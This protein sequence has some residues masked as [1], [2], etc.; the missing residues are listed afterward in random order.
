M[1][2]LIGLEMQ[3]RML[4]DLRQRLLGL[5]GLQVGLTI[6]LLAVAGADRRPALEPG[7]R[8]RDHPVAVVDGDRDADAGR[9]EA[10]ADRGRAGGL[11]GAALPGR[12]GASA[13][14]G[15]AA[16]GARRARRRSR[17][18]ARR[19]GARGCLALD[20][21]GA[22]GRR[23]RAGGAGGA[24]SDPADLPLPR[25]GEA[26]GDP[27]RRGAA[28]DRRHLA[29]DG[30][31]RAVAGARVVPRRRG[32]GGLGLPAPA[33]GR[34]RAV[35]GDP[36]R[37]VL[38]HRGRGG[39]SRPSG[40]GSAADPAAD[41]DAA[42]GED[43]GALA[44][45]GGVRAAGEGAAALHAGAGAGRGVRLLPARVRHREPGAEPGRRRDAAAG[46]RLL[47][48]ADAGA[49]LAA[50]ADRGADAATGRGAKP[51]RSTRRAR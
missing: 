31:A 51:T 1:L 29:D 49:L 45:L 9:E 34:S 38:H 11:R 35:Q 3:P 25:R 22:G 40:R 15:P 19:R 48:D 4:W 42:A 2:F 12:G 8:G 21:G 7:D 28:P 20:A 14:G 5:G 41:A 18:A 17:G 46:D 13:A 16:A 50:R 23:R 27:G 43:G 36:A 47:D 37:A 44:A 24:V 30:L 26:A 39:R 32:A 10:D 6:A 33:R